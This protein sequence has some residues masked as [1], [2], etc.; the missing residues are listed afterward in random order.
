MNVRVADV[1][2]NSDHE[3]SQLRRA[4]DSAIYSLE[5][6]KRRAEQGATSESADWDCLLI[7]EAADAAIERI[8]ASFP[9]ADNVVRP[10]FGR[11]DDPKLVRPNQA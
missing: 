11:K 6:I 5:Q 8:S 1:Q 2:T 3:L 7:A 4:L 10:S 9:R